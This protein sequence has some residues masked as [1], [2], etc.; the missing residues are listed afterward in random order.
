M[1]KPADLGQTAAS[2]QAESPVDAAIGTLE[3]VHHFYD[4]MPTGVT[5]SHGGRIFINYPRWGDDVS[6]TVG[7]LRDG[8]EVAYPNLAANQP[9]HS[10]DPDALVSVQSVVVDPLDRLWILDTGR[11]MWDPATPG[12][13]KLVCVDLETDAV[14]QTI[15]FDPEVAPAT[16]YLNDVRFDLG[17]GAAG[18]AFISDSADGAPNAIIAVDLDSGEAWRRLHEHPST[19]AVLPPD[20]RIVIEG[21]QL[22]KRPPDGPRAPLAVGVDG[23]AISADGERLYYSPFASRRLWSA[24]VDAL[25]DR[26]SDA[27]AVASVVDEGDKGS[28]GDGMETDAEGR[29][30]ITAGERNSVDRLLLDGT[31]ETVV[32]DAR[33]LWP[34]TLSIAADGYLYVTANQL[35]RDAGFRDGVD[36]RRK[37]Y[38]LFRTRIGS[39]PAM[40][41]RTSGGTA[42]APARRRPP[43]SDEPEHASPPSPP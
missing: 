17:R 41:H 43:S 9:A 42:G 38:T 18:T 30:Y 1:T 14:V 12:G 31:W 24:A 6:F 22:L 2:D 5:V 4:A 15:V 34:D 11:P 29:I 40:R 33:L 7:E 10:G 32:H 37:P 39:G 25:M 20:L 3:V 16:T 19:K 27:A 36:E 26:D 35:Y 23:I 13:P 21:E 28:A 8:A